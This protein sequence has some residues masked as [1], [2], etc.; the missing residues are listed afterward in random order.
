MSFCETHK[1]SIIL[2]RI[3]N[4]KLIDTNKFQAITKTNFTACLH[5]Y[6]I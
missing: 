1:E 4:L 3:F 6:L 2:L 5:I